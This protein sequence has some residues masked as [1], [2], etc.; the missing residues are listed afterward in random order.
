VARDAQWS[1]GGSA[2]W[3]LSWYCL[4]VLVLALNG[5]TEAFVYAVATKDQVRGQG[6]GAR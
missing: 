6:E 3:V 2:A 5:M 1:G 4:Y